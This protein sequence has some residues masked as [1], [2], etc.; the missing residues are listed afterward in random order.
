MTD[1]PPRPTRS[2]GPSW[3]DGKRAIEITCPKCAEPYTIVSW[4]GPFNLLCWSHPR[5][6]LHRYCRTCGYGWIQQ[7]HAE[8]ISEIHEQKEPT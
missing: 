5:G 7:A 3:A 4:H 8:A 1:A 2:V 6:H